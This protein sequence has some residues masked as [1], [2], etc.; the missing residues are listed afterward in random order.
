M[1]EPRR[2]ARL[3]V[4]A[5]CGAPLVSLAQFTPLPAPVPA[6]VTNRPPT[7]IKSDSLEADLFKRKAIFRGNVVV[8]DAAF[9]MTAMQMDVEFND[10]ANGV[11][12]I[13]ARGKVRIDQADKSAIA[14][15]ATYFVADA[16]IELV[17]SPK[18]FSGKNEL[19]GEK[20]TFFRNENKLL[21]SGGTTLNLESMQGLEFTPKPQAPPGSSDGLMPPGLNP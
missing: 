1:I 14:D 19:A 21:V 4:A 16:R 11:D 12:R 6:A 10:K 15:E 7:V 20:I 17:G 9:R 13:V 2:A 18:A 8:T 5:L 3:L